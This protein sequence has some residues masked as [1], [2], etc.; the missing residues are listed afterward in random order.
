M[1]FAGG[2]WA[3][4]MTASKSSKYTYSHPVWTSPTPIAE[5]AVPTELGTAADAV[6]PMFWSYNGT[7]ALLCMG[8][9]VHCQG[10]YTPNRVKGSISTI[11]RQTPVAAAHQN[12]NPATDTCTTT[13]CQGNQKPGELFEGANAVY[14]GKTWW[15]FGIINENNSWGSSFLPP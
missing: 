9:L 1:E 10:F 5:A 7:Q 11:V 8:D 12:A 13:F 3:L 2:G 6:S 14:S 4:V 15:R